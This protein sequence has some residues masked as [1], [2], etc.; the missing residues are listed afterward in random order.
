M[1]IEPTAMWI[2]IAEHGFR[3]HLATDTFVSF[4]GRSN[5]HVRD[6]V[7]L[8]DGRITKIGEGRQHFE[9]ISESSTCK[10]CLSK[11]KILQEIE[12]SIYY[13]KTEVK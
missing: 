9:I 3:Y 7:E 11:A 5:L 4:C 8:V 10:I 2:M 6:Y 12:K 1:R 13:P